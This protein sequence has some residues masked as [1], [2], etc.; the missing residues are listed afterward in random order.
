[1]KNQKI[2]MAVAS[3]GFALVALPVFAD[4]V[5]VSGTVEGAKG[6]SLPI[7]ISDKKDNIKDVLKMRQNVE[8]EMRIKKMAVTVASSSKDMDARREEFKKQFESKKEE[9]KKKIEDEKV[10]LAEKLKTIK[11]ERKKEVIKKISGQFQEI[12]TKKLEHFSNVLKQMEGVLVKI[13]A[14]AEKA[15]AGGADMSALNVKIA[16]F[17]TAVTTARA[18]IVAQSAKV[19]SIE[20]TTDE[21]LKNNTGAT[22][23]ALQKDLK[24]VF[25]LVKNAHEA[26][27]GI[28]KELAKIRIVGSEEH[29]ST[30]PAIATTTTTTTAT[31]TNQ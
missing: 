10:R 4:E 12:N 3:L 15:T 9:A 22:R 13:K 14:R 20:V 16:A 24:T 7:R 5:T 31:T 21:H 11:D 2:L 18:A 1:M 19:Y 29:A 28:T 6:S 8:Q 25:D 17:E 30:T 27:K 26:L 23:Q